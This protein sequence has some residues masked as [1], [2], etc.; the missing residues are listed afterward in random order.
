MFAQNIW[1]RLRTLL[2]MA[3]EREKE[4]E[5]ELRLHLELRAEE[6]LSQGYS[7]TEARQRAAESFGDP[8]EVIQEALAGQGK[9]PPRQTESWLRTIW[10]DLRH[11]ARLLRKSPLFTAAVV[12]T[13]ALGIGADTA[14]FS[15]VHGILLK[16]LPYKNAARVVR[17]FERNLA[18]NSTRSLNSPADLVDMKSQSDVFETVSVYRWNTPTLTGIG[19][20]EQVSVAIVTNEFFSTLGVTPAIGRLFD[21]PELAGSGGPASVT[22]DSPAVNGGGQGTAI[23]ISESVWKRKF[24]GDPRVLGKSLTL[25]GGLCSIIGVMPAGFHYPIESG[26]NQTQLWIGGDVLQREQ[27]SRGSRML[28]AT[29][30]LKPGVKAAAAQREL[31]IISARLAQA[32]PKQDLGWSFNVVGMREDVVRDTRTPLLIL[33]AA[34][35]LLLLIAC[36]NVANLLLT[37]AAAR[38]REI[39]I[40][41][42]LGAGRWRLI[43]QLLTESLLLALAGGAA[44]AAAAWAGMRVLRASLPNDLPRT[45]EVQMSGAV[46]LFALATSAFV[47]IIFGLIPAASVAKQRLN[48]SLKESRTT[49]ASGFRLLRHHR[50]RSI[51]VIA[52]VAL[53]V[54]LLVGSGLLAKSFVRLISVN[55]GFQTDHV[56]TFWV[57]PPQ[58]SY[59]K[60]T[61]R[62]NL[63]SQMVERFRT[64]PG[65]QSAAVTSFLALSGYATTDYQ[66]ISRPKP[67]EGAEPEAEYK[68][69]SPDYFSVLRIPLLRGRFF[70][71]GDVRNAPPVALVNQVF[72]QREFPTGNPIGE[73][74]K[75]NWGAESAWR[76]IIGIVGDTR[77]ASLQKDAQ[78]QFY[79]PM[80]QSSVSPSVAFLLR[81]SGDPLAIVG[82]VRA[83]AASVDQNQPI[84]S[85][86]TLAELYSGQ[87]AE[88][89]F[90]AWLI[91]VFSLLALALA[92]VGLYAVM[93]Y[94]VSERTHEIGVRMA[95]GAEAGN[96]VALVA[97]Q[98]I[99]LV[100]AGLVI[101]IAAALILSRVLATL[102]FGIQPNDPATVAQAAAL[103]AVAG[104][105]ACWMPVR[106]A[107]R[108]DPLIALRYE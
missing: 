2:G 24:A 17:L 43:R 32:Y 3:S 104:L 37:R 34:V 72:A 86:D 62:S 50:S 56:L 103:L 8:R 88:P 1:S 13:L 70:G 63:Y 33:F 38:R 30:L 77:D 40:R 47:G 61:A 67:T 89:R 51:L 92:A 84:S 27:K 28:P 58:Q 85:I 87:I 57:D 55:L 23:L 91:G 36:A 81:T 15:V 52:Q 102:L 98:G 20:P 14:V 100:A 108:I 42:A 69:I 25:D 78:P 53:S 41:A 107:T 76:E 66:I 10:P 48:D 12:L 19:D 83:A 5:E 49:T 97:R 93:A 99:A 39:A 54:V 96:V 31:D 22:G 4:I 95:I 65:V 7:Q 11:S 29:A 79:V 6:F 46:L 90:E 68:A 26:P 9:T 106:R 74:I 75:I 80:D 105:A 16:P 82:S 71:E 59:G 60:N 21:P 18:K 45:A 94:S 35:T 73:K 64:L 44:G 101:G